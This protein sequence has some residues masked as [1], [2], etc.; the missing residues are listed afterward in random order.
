MDENERM[1]TVGTYINLWT[2]QGDYDV[3]ITLNEAN[4]LPTPDE[5]DEIGNKIRPI[6]ESDE[7]EKQKVAEDVLNNLELNCLTFGGQVTVRERR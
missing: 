5:V 7:K 6:F 2:T 4:D 1:T 3:F